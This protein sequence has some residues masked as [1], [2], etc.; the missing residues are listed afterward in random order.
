MSAWD[1]PRRGKGR[2]APARDPWYRAV[3][4]VSVNTVASRERKKFESQLPDGKD[5]APTVLDLLDT[6]V[7][8]TMEGRSWVARAT[9]EAAG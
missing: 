4:A 1:H 7:P 5:I 9:V 2:L 6:P 8:E 3:L